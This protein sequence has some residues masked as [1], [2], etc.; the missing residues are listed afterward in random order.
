MQKPDLPEVA[1]LREVS[2]CMV[3]LLMQCPCLLDSGA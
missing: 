2:P 3:E 1:S